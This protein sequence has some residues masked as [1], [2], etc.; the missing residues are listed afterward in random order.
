MHELQEALSY[1][2]ER[3]PKIFLSPAPKSLMKLTPVI[4]SP[5]TTPLYS[6]MVLP[7]T[8]GVVV[9]IMIIS[10]SISISNETLQI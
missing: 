7:S 10:I 5:N 6:T 4:T 2:P 8:D 3:P 1:E 9:S